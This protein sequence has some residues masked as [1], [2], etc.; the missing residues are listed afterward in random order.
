MNRQVIKNRIRKTLAYGVT[1]VVFLIISAF[2]ILQMPPVQNA[3]VGRLLKNF[4]G[5]VGF[6]TTVHHFHLYWF[7][8]I[9]L[10]GVSVVDPETNEMIHAKR[11]LINFK[12]AQLFQQHDID[13]DG[14][15]VDS[16]HVYLTKIAESDTSADLNINL[17]IYQINN[18]FSK[19]SSTGNPPQ[20]NIGE[21]VLNQCRFTYIDQYRDTVPSG[22]D[23]NHFTLDIDEGQLRNFMVLGDT[24]QFDVAT[25]LVEDQ[26][27]KFK[28]KQLS[29]FFRISQSSMEFNG[30]NLHAGQSTIT[31]TV[32]FTYNSQRDLNQFVDN[33][34]IHAHF[35]NTIIYPEDLALFAP[36]AKA[37]EKPVHLSGTMNGRIRKFKLTD[38]EATM[39]NT[40][41]LGSLDM[42]GLP[43]INETLII[44]N[45]KNSQLE[46]DDFDF[47]FNEK[48]LARLRPFGRF[49]L[50]GQFLGYP[51]DFVATGDFS[52]ALGRIRSDINFKVNEVDIDRSSYTGKLA[53]INF[54]L[55]EYL[56]DTST[57]QKVNLDGRI[58][59]SGL[60]LET[61]DFKLNGKV[62]SLGIKGYNYTNI[63]TNAHF[64]SQF[65]NGL[66]TINDP[67]L[68]FS[69]KGSIDLRKGKNIVTVQASLDTALL[70]NLKLS[71]QKI[72]LQ[73]KVDLD[74]AGL[75][76]DS[77]IG[78]AR[79]TDFNIHY[80]NKS[81]AV[82][83]IHLISRRNAAFR[84]I[85]LETPL[86]DARLEGN[87]LVTDVTNDIKN[88]LYEISLNIKNNEE[89]ITQYYQ[90][91]RTQPKTYQTS[92]NVN[93]KNINPVTELLNLDLLVS[94]GTIIQGNFSSGY[95]TILRA[96]TFVDSMEYE[97]NLLVKTEAEITASKIAD[98]TSVLAMAFLNSAQQKLKSGLKT[99]NL[100][101]EGIWNRNHID[102]TLDC[103]QQNT[104]NYIRLRGMTDF[105][106]DTTAIKFLPSAIHLLERNWL[107]EP[108]NEITVQGTEWRFNNVR[109][110]NQEQ[111]LQMNGFLSEDSTKNLR[112]QVN[113]LDLSV[114]N[115]IS[116]VRFAG[117]MDADILMNNFFRDTNIENDVTVKG[118]SVEDF[119]IGDITGQNHWDNER[120]KFDINFFI[121]KNNERLVNLAGD[122]TPG[123]ADP[124]H[125]E[126]TLDK[127]NLK[128]IE[129]FLQDIFSNIGG[130]VTGS[131]I[132]TGTLDNPIIQGKGTVNNGYLTVNY[133]RT[134]YRFNGVIELT[135]SSINFNNIELTDG[136]R[137][138]ATLSGHIVH[139]NFSNMRINLDARFQ[140]FQIL[141]TSARDND[142][143][144]GQ[145]YA[146]GNVNFFGPMENL[147]ISSSARTEKNTRIYIPVSGTSSTE[148]KEFINFVSLSDSGTVAEKPE[149]KHE[150]KVNLTGVTLDLNLDVTP[151][152]YCEIIFDIKAGD[153][154]RGRG[155]GE[156]KLQMDTKGEF[157]MFGVVEFTEGWYNFTLYDII[158]KEFEIQKGSRITWFGDPY[159]ATLDIKASYNQLASFG[160]VVDYVYEG[161]DFG[162]T[163]EL[164][165][166]YPAQVFLK[167]DGPMLSPQINFD[168]LARDLPQTIAVNVDGV[169]NS[170]RLDFAFQAFKNKLDEQ[171]L[172]KQVFSLIVLRKF[173]PPQTFKT[174]VE[175]LYNS[176]SE[177][178]SNQLSYWMSQV[179]ENLEID[180][181]L[182]T[183]DEE[184]F[185]TF[186]LRLSYTFFNGRLRITR[187]GTFGNN[188]YNGPTENRG[189]L[190]SIAGDWTVDY[191]LTA[192]GK[193]KVKMY[194]RTNYNQLS[195]SLNNQNYF[196]TGVSLQHVQSF[197][198]LKDLLN[199][200]RNKKGKRPSETNPEIN[201]EAIREDEN[202]M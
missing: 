63:I 202:D 146:S 182:G 172:K 57:F 55:G 8:R 139:R 60:T 36:P 116:A 143:F 118:L 56:G 1:G 180:L 27:T 88:L 135:P 147:K 51:T 124:L 106:R 25:L 140:N 191:F 2:L 170:I 68:E 169:S 11:L 30:L 22:F 155:N 125:V 153:I 133:L 105:L 73:T 190:A 54:N 154:I 127:A 131:Y 103:D 65:F 43:D 101:A 126:A 50:N 83:S 32:F 87:F 174:N 144:Y 66:L 120:E 49:S 3:I 194:N 37:I 150:N 70:H 92:F 175:S 136:Y 42:D 162:T 167:L 48:A 181:D 193:F 10:E 16:A 33:V 96:F 24:T 85:S 188:D 14:I 201:E 198:E 128:I 164:R 129:P 99:N 141:N 67:N 97:K 110:T 160:P 107:V 44:L 78:N 71:S 75:Q 161:S 145:A 173:S 112:L 17:F 94:R 123:K 151:D 4:S 26:K 114:L 35:D 74:I 187:D 111:S 40:R 76:L 79:F 61:A 142:L 122:Y 109:L 197:N 183:M 7:D 5:A 165:R 41:L 13:I 152:A 45:L 163:P 119:L 91:K 95:T 195:T 177:L 113:H 23:Y 69:A 39:G 137:N 31:D 132:I 104:G 15:I 93:L 149:Q 178:L 59:G 34:K 86:A 171:E 80:E 166:K 108:Q 52:G 168:I 19:G 199:F 62:N 184:R 159:A 82:D 156:L 115:V 157:N 18:A 98:S 189:N 179:D 192:D 20:V 176:V 28:I 64:A 72:F 81:L 148:R 29:T 53:M 186:Q 21:A 12:L 102:F 38:M 84:H 6:Q 200:S 89:E 121:D 134:G 138:N 90:T 77:L 9:E 100:I 58:S 46:F 185:N 117:V 196:T 47:L 158:N 130:T